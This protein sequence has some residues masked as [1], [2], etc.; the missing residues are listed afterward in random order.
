MSLA[1]IPARC[2]SKRIPGKN[3]RDIG[4]RPMI[5]WAI[6]AAL[7]SELFDDIVVSTDSEE[8]AAIAQDSGATVPFIRPAELSDDFT[9]TIE[10]IAHAARWAVERDRS[11]D[12][13]CCI[14]P[15]ACLLLP[16]DL[17]KG[18]TRLQDGWDYVCAAGQ[19][20]RPVQRGFVRTDRG[21]MRM[22]FPEHRLTRTQ[23]L[24]PVF[25]DAGQFYWG[26]SDAWI[27]ERPILSERTSF[28][29]LPAERAC[30]IDTL[31]DWAFAEAALIKLKGPNHEQ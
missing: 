25:F 19:F 10:V 1:V 28:V 18:H 7:A 31:D 22:L 13:I 11:S 24:P 21:A 8:I 27:E 29:E 2:G 23:D 12:A 17:R 20:A 30:D 6:E 26:R 5:A 3:V 16:S 4:G 14:Y 15:T 9:G